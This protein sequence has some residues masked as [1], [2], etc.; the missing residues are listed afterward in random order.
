MSAQPTSASAAKARGPAR[1][2]RW[3]RRLAV[4]L[5]LIV[6]ARVAL[7][8]ALVPLARAGAR[9]AGFELSIERL[10]LRILAGD[11]TVGDAT[12]FIAADAPAQ[13]TNAPEQTPVAHL[14]HLRIDIATSAL[15]RGAVRIERL[16]VDGLAL[17][18]ERNADGSWPLLRV[19][20]AG[21][22]DSEPA[23]RDAGTPKTPDFSSPIEIGAVRI[24]G[25]SLTVLDRTVDP[26]GRARFEA[27]LRLADVGPDVGPARLAI[28]LSG[29]GT[30]GAPLLRTATVTGRAT[31]LPERVVAD[32][33]AQMAGLDLKPLAPLLAAFG[34]APA[35]QERDGGLRAR[36]MLERRGVDP[37]RVGLRAAVQDAHWSV[38]GV[39]SLAL[40][41]LDVDAEFGPDSLR[42]EEV[43]IDGT[44]VRGARR[45][46]GAF[47]FAGVA[48]V[49]ATAPTPAPTP[50]PNGSDGAT[51]SPNDSAA[52]LAEGWPPIAIALFDVSR[53]QLIF[54][55]GLFDPPLT[56]RTRIDRFSIDDLNLVRPDGAPARIELRASAAGVLGEVWFDGELVADDQTLRLRASGT[57]GPLELDAVAPYLAAAGLARTG[58]ARSAEGALDLTLRRDANGLRVDFAARDLRLVANQEVANAEPDAR[59]DLVEWTGAALGAERANLGALNVRGGAIHVELDAANHWRFA[60]L[61]PRKGGALP[62]PAP[63]AITQPAG[64]D[65]EEDGQDA[66]NPSAGTHT[67][68]EGTLDPAAAAP[69]TPAERTPTA[70][71]RIAIQGVSV[72]DVGL[73]I[74]QRSPGGERRLDAVEA[75][76]DVGAFE[77]F[78]ATPSDAAVRAGVSAPGLL[79]TLEV[80]GT[81][82]SDA[83]T[84]G[85]R[86]ELHAKGLAP[87]RL[88]PW[89]PAGLPR[90]TWKAAD[91]R[92]TAL[93]G[94]DLAESDPRVHFELT[95]WRLLEE[96]VSLASLD[97][98]ALPEVRLGAVLDLGAI[99]I[100][101]PRIA[102]ARRADGT[103]S[104]AGVALF[105][106]ANTAQSTGV[107]GQSE[108]GAGP[109]A[110]AESRATAEPVSAAEEAPVAEAAPTENAAPPAS[111]FVLPAV[112]VGPVSL[113]G[114]HVAWTDRAGRETIEAS[115]T[116]NASLG[117]LDL[118]S[119]AE[120]TAFGAELDLGG[121]AP[122]TIEGELRPDLAQLLLNARLRGTALGAGG[123]EAYL[124]PG[125]SLGSDAGRLRAD[126]SVAAGLDGMTIRGLDAGLFD[127]AWDAPDENAYLA[128]DSLRLRAP[129]L[130]P[131]APRYVIDELSLAGLR[132]D[133]ELG[134]EGRLDVLGLAF[135]PAARTLAL[136]P[137]TADPKLPIQP[138]ADASGTQD[139]TMR[140]PLP[141]VPPN[142]LDFAAIP[143][144]ELGAFELELAQLRIVDAS[145]PPEAEPLVLSGRIATPGPA[146]LIS[147]DSAALPPFE[148]FLEASA[149]PA[150]GSV[151]ADLALAPF[152][153]EPGLVFEAL[154]KGLSSSGLVATLPA[155]E[156]WIGPGALEGG[157]AHTRLETHLNW[158][159]RGPLDFGYA[160]GFAGELR[161]AATE[162]L[163]SP[164]G[165][166]LAGLEQINVDWR[167][168][169]PATLELHV[170]VLELVKPTL[171]V[172]Q[173]AEGIE[174]FGVLVRTPVDDVAPSEG[175]SGAGDGA[176]VDGNSSESL[177]LEQDPSFGAETPSGAAAAAGDVAQ[178]AAAEPVR[179]Q[180]IG[181]ATAAGSEVAGAPDVPLLRIDTLVVR[182]IDVRYEDQTTDP[183]TIVPLNQLDLEVRGLTS[184]ALTE[185]V[186]IPF[187]L[188]LGAGAVPLP[189]RSASRSFLGGL[190]SAA[191]AL[192]GTNSEPTATQMRPLFGELALIGRIAPAPRP[193]GWARL[194]LDGF[195]LAGLRGLA[196]QSGVTIRDGV[197]DARVRVDLEADGVLEVDT[198]STFTHLSLSEPSN[199]PISRFLRLPAPLDTVLFTLRN[200]DGEQRIPLDFR[201]S[202]GGVSAGAIAGRAT[203]A[204]AGLITDAIASSPLRLTGGLTDIVGLGSDA[205]PADAGVPKVVVTFEPGS[206][207]LMPEAVRGLKQIARRLAD[208]DELRVVLE[209]RLCAPDLQRSS[210]LAN[211]SVDDARD[212]AMHLGER[213]DEIAR[214]R[215]LLAVQVRSAFALGLVEEAERL[216]A[217]LLAAEIEF[218]DVEEAIDHMLALL[219]PGAER[220]AERRTRA[221]A[222]ALGAL[223]QVEVRDALIE[224]GAPKG[225]NRI[226]IRRARYEIAAEERGAV[227]VF[228]RGG[229]P[230]RGFFGRVLGFF[231]L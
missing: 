118:S 113:A 188:Y 55:D 66:G 85:L 79:K 172:V 30:D 210:I 35:G 201:V 69:T 174:V 187:S 22:S 71:P 176:S 217:Q 72:R 175:G 164:D 150:I 198:T 128:F 108:S 122:L 223:R 90:P 100:V 105:E 83:R 166:R 221:A 228:E 51:P 203:T 147:A 2:R 58:A 231:G 3:L 215:A 220:R 205:V 146:V 106:P 9:A 192:I 226:E 75:H 159:R 6:A 110:A 104:V 165:E 96:G 12:L 135:D 214:R 103:L 140:R 10:E 46:D 167:R 148:I 36:V 141:A 24:T 19:L 208:D 101:N 136:G 120:T 38:D 102:L 97:R 52:P 62:L 168:F 114:L 109:V 50:I 126:L 117:R 99:D 138:P 190:T 28:E 204:L 181:P 229:T 54:E 133:V 13:E 64:E 225:E 218:A 144:V 134:R 89:W 92:G 179:V 70:L 185:P 8:F 73:S 132:L 16:D 129:L 60:G 111:P 137:Q 173:R 209:H 15:L 139:D 145:A 183:V 107:E 161:I 74:T 121:A 211:P 44:V 143:H 53:L 186:A 17:H 202:D 155:L 98:F 195:E 131:Q 57:A 191:G 163:A 67:V 41:R 219:R 27:E 42:V 20:S 31:V 78:G 151:R 5:V 18:V 95:D 130:D 189:E 184:S 115:A 158:R 14:V 76:L 91:A 65:G 216:R 39:P 43:S 116:L 1:R 33:E 227:L 88:A 177:A 82:N 94:V 178:S 171:H 80:T 170:E 23:P 56:L 49:P 26:V 180:T 213:R 112:A 142:G 196:R 37:A 119:P 160:D 125:W 212:L 157:Q 86:L 206:V 7:A 93:F 197:L 87:D 149:P 84:L 152:R 153:D 156:R 61:G 32:V 21:S 47:L 230:R 224:L 154:A 34:L 77:L 194:D 200:Q 162:L 81:V 193:T 4:L 207:H 63:R 169:V 127:V 29:Q 123:F 59:L 199:G 45:A 182:D 222:L 68:A 25:A 48:T 124:P 11:L 40:A